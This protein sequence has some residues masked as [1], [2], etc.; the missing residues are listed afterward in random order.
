MELSLFKE[1]YIEPWAPERLRLL[2]ERNKDKNSAGGNVSDFYLYVWIEEL[3]YCSGFQAILDD[4]F[5]LEFHGPFRLTFG[6]ISAKPLGRA[7][8]EIEESAFVNE[9]E[10]IMASMGSMHCDQFP[11]LIKQIGEV[12][13]RNSSTRI[14]MTVDEKKYLEK[15]LKKA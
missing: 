14:N 12:A 15:I 5:V 9:R 11:D 13:R 10:R 4:E 6:R 8:M 2:F 7:I 1:P 3:L